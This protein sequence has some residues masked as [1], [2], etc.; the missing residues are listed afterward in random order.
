LAIF[1]ADYSRLGS[2]ETQRSQGSMRSLWS[3]K[4]AQLVEIFFDSMKE[5]LAAGH[6]TELPSLKISG[7]GTWQVREKEERMGRNPQTGEVLPISAR[8]V[9]TFKASQKLRD[10]V[11]GSAGVNGENLDRGDGG[12]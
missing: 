7:F 1:T 6:A 4:K 9:V 2:L 3:S 12:E 10:G 8:R 5:S 11:N